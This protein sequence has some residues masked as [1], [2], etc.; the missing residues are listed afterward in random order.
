M[1][2]Q[3]AAKPRRSPGPARLIA[4]TVA[5]LGV[6]VLIGLLPNFAGLL[7]HDALSDVRAYYDAGAR[8]N[9][10]L[11]LYDTTIDVNASEFYRYPPLLAILFRPVAALMSYEVA[12]ILWGIGMVVAFA[13]TVWWLGVRRFGTWA[14]VAALSFPIAWCLALGQAQ[15]LVTL[16]LTVASPATVAF[17]GQLK[18]LPALVALYWLGRREWRPLGIFLAWT[19]GLVLFQVIVEPGGF[20]AFLE[21]TNLSQVGD[22]N[23]LSPYEASPALWAVLAV[24]GLVAT[25]ALA[26]TRWGWAAAVAYSVLVT[27][28]LLAY[29]LMGLLACLSDP[30]RKPAA[31][32]EPVPS[33]G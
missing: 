29:L 11:P 21:V 10:G 23:N 22:I 12:A 18:L 30:K 15:V 14:A 24:V 4:F 16:L 20:R 33:G 19:A 1:L 25:I 31:D 7:S 27:P 3:E 5:V 6:L 9:A 2:A 28:R 32:S 13:A 8:L 26:R 17:A